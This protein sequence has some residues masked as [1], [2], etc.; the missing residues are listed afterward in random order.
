MENDA[1]AISKYLPL[2][3]GYSVFNHPVIK[4]LR[5][6]SYRIA[7][8]EPKYT[9]FWDAELVLKAWEV[10]NESLSLLDLS[11]KTYTLCKLMSMGRDADVTN[12]QIPQRDPLSY[13]K[14]N[15]Q[16]IVLKMNNN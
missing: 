3:D 14:D 16:F 10:P 2:V 1:A 11:R 12:F 7:P 15:T 4:R 5:Q 6:A 8:P 9:E 13:D